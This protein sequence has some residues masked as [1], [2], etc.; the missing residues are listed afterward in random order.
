MAEGGRILVKVL[1][2]IAASVK[3]GIATKDLNALA[4][5]LISSHGA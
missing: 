4:R 1:K 5:K 3:P 2:E